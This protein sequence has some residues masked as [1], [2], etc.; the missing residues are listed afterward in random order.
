MRWGSKNKKMLQMANFWPFF[1][2]GGKSLRWGWA[3]PPCSLGTATLLTQKILKILTVWYSLGFITD[4]QGVA[5][6]WKLKGHHGDI[7]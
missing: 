5:N 6:F 2:G 7:L 1:S 3:V 4:S